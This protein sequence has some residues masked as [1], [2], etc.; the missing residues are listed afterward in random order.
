MERREGDKS[1]RSG[2]MA[3]LVRRHREVKRK[4][5]KKAQQQQYDRVL[6]VIMSL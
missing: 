5:E 1:V 6:P 2:G 3:V 4:K